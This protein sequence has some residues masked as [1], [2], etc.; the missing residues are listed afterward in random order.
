MTLPD[1]LTQDADGEIH[2]T[3]HRIGLYTVV[4]CNRDGYTAE[5]I[6]EEFPTLPLDLIR[7]T[8][9]FYQANQ[10]EVDTYMDEYGTELDRQA[11]APQKG[12]SLE[13][14]RRRWKA[15]GL[16]PLP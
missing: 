8:L 7:K 11:A 4:S 5:R 1:F 10:S 6:A 2:M 12:P 14:L 16:G 9:A 15:K 13:E 3:G